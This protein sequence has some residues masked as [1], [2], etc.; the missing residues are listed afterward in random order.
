MDFETYV[1]GLIMASSAVKTLHWFLFWIYVSLFK[2]YHICSILLGSSWNYPL[3]VCLMIFVSWAEINV[4]KID[5]LHQFGARQRFRQMVDMVEV[6][7]SETEKSEFD[8]HYDEVIAEDELNLN[9]RP[10][11]EP[12][13]Y[14]DYEDNADGDIINA[15]NIE[16]LNDELEPLEFSDKGTLYNRDS[17]I[18]AEYD[19]L[20]R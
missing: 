18:Y 3:L 6:Y 15:E 17:M 7:M 8:S 16:P 12:H 19:E 10:G 1:F 20:I 5:Q 2:Q 14:D 4:E 9:T 11:R 13:I